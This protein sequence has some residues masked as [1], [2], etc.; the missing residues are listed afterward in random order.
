MTVAFP[1]TLYRLVTTAVSKVD[2][3]RF[4]SSPRPPDKT[5]VAALFY[6]HQILSTAGNASMDLRD[7]LHDS[8][9][10]MDLHLSKVLNW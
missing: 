6:G 10:E 8:I 4:T 5:I 7:D 1:I 3:R 2:G 9:M